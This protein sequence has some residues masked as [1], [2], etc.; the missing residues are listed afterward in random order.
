MTLSSGQ[1]LTVVGAP[2]SASQSAGAW[3]TPAQAAALGATD[4][5]MLYRFAQ[6][7]TATQVRAD[8]ASV[9]NGLPHGALAGSQSY[10]TLEQQYSTSVAGS[11]VPFLLTFGVLA[12][13]VD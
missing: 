9:T 5:Q 1:V 6:A 8:L 7:A 12:L 4:D 11:Y 13:V 10:L 3:A 2:Y